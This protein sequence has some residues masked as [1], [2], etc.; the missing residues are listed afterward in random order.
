MKLLRLNVNTTQRITFNQISE[1][2]IQDAL[3]N[4]GV[5]NKHLYH[6]QQARAVIDIVF[7]FL[8]SPFLSKHMN[9]HALSAGRCQSPAMRMIYQ[10]QKEQIHGPKTIQIC[11]QSTDLPKINHIKPE[12]KDKAY[13]TDWLQNLIQQQFIV[14]STK[15]Q[16]KKEMPPPPF[17]TSSLQ[18]CA[19]SLY[20][21]NPKHTMQLAQT[22]Y[23]GGYITYMRTDS[24]SLNAQ[25]QD[26]VIS[27]VTNTFGNKYACKRNYSTKGNQ[28]T[29]DAHEAIRP[30]SLEKSL[31]EDPDMSKLYTL[32]R[33]RAIASQMCAAIYK[34]S[35]L[36]LTTN[37]RNSTTQDFWESIQRSLLFPGYK[38][39][40]GT[41]TNTP[42]DSCDSN[43]IPQSRYH[44]FNQ[45]CACI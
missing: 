21:Y 16:E 3:A 43:I 23:E 34:E 27:F 44:I 28:K 19:Y 35:K 6:A 37:R 32:I 18:Q 38:I 31:P 26:D 9:I 36:V 40:K 33:D 24:V 30:L 13:I 4:P 8:V 39:L 10:R 22:L 7:G 1:K 45:K 11:G 29:Q 14:H 42:D 12:I 41:H 2:A 15:I 5:L 20:G 17:I 25:F